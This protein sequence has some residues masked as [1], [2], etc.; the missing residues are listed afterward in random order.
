MH[1]VVMA[2]HARTGLARAML[3]SVADRMLQA[4]APVLLVRPN[5]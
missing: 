1:L 4:T 2:T 3:G 5:P